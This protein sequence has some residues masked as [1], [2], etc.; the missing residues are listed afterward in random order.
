MSEA[1]VAGVLYARSTRSPVLSYL[2]KKM[3]ESGRTSGISPEA[4]Q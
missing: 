3:R 2:T 1:S 4:Q